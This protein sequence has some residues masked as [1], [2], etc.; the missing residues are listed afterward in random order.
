M[1]LELVIARITA[2]FSNARFRDCYKLFM[3]GIQWG[4]DSTMQDLSERYQDANARY[5]APFL[6]ERP[7]I[8]ENYLENYVYRHLFPFGPQETTYKLRDQMIERSI[9]AEYMLLAAY[10]SIAEMLLCGVAGFYKEA[11]GATHV[12]QVI[13]SCT[14][15]FEHSLTFP[16]RV[17][18]MLEKKGLHLSAGAAVLLTGE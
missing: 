15:A 9:H 11:F 2:D 1:L 17:L 10:Y 8:L 13:Y 4:K 16:Q 3:E 12:V 7:H 14:R 6:R 5:C 18:Q